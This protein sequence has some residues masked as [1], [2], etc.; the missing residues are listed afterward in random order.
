[1]LIDGASNGKSIAVA[2]F[3]PA[4]GSP[5]ICVGEKV[6]NS[7]PAAAICDD[8]V[9]EVLPVSLPLDKGVEWA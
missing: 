1:M 2:Y 5:G 9:P 7:V 6:T 4:Y 8:A 3:G